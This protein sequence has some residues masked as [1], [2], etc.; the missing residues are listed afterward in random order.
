MRDRQRMKVNWA[1]QEWRIE[2]KVG[3]VMILW[4]DRTGLNDCVLTPAS[5]SFAHMFVWMHGQME[6]NVIQ[7]DLV[8]YD[9]TGCASVILLL[10]EKRRGS[11]WESKVHKEVIKQIYKSRCTAT[12]KESKAS[13][14]R[15]R[16]C[17]CKWFRKSFVK[18][19]FHLRQR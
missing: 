14:L 17:S 9:W 5:I 7:L 1:W 11:S 2:V 19:I 6:F 10:G 4:N 8:L 3:S 12:N 13:Q 18:G 16:K 15:W